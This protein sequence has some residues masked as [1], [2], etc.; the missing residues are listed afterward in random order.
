M[1]QNIISW[2]FTIL[3]IVI[4]VLNIIL[5]HPV[6][7]IF[8]LVLSVA[9]LP[10]TNTF[11]KKKFNISIPFAAKVIVGFVVLW[12]TLGVTDLAEILGL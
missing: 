4:G 3:F 1:S 12:G 6:P 10:A 7:G 5:V 11:L 9:Y 8:Y 2:I